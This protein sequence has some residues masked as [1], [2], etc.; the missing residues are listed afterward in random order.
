MSPQIMVAFNLYL[1]ISY[2]RIFWW[3][4]PANQLIWYSK[5]LIIYRGFFTSQ[6]V[7]WNFLPWTV[8]LCTRTNILLIYKQKT[9]SVCVGVEFWTLPL[10]KFPPLTTED[11]CERYLK[12]C[13]LQSPIGP[14]PGAG[15]GFF[16]KP[17]RGVFSASRVTQRGKDQQVFS[18][19]FLRRNQ[20]RW[21]QLKYDLCSPRKFGEDSHFG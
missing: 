12:R 14:L 16:W 6:V 8:V 3:K 1:Y 7:V 21:W 19:H 15:H 20:S 10:Y 5:Y 2:I 18:C 11:T 13:L 4:H 17:G 9:P